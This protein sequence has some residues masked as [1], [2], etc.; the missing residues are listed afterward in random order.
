MPLFH[1]Y[2]YFLYATSTGKT[3]YYLRRLNTWAKTSISLKLISIAILILILLIPSSMLTSLI[4]ERERY[5]DDA[6][7]EVSGKW[8]DSQ[9]IGGPVLTI[10][11]EVVLEDAKGKVSTVTEYAHFLPEDLAYYR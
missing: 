10:P 5:R 2:Y 8:G 7:N 1:I 4:Y 11:Y 6:I 3:L 9:T